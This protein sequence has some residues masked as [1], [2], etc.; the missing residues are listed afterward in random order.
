MEHA[1]QPTALVI[2]GGIA[3]LSA[4]WFLQQSRRMRI[5]LIEASGR[6]GGKVETTQDG[7]YRVEHGPD[8]FITRKPWALRLIRELGLHDQLVPLNPLPDRIAVLRG[9]RLVPMPEGLELLAPTELW[10]F[11]TS[12]LFSP[13]GKL[14]ILAEA[15]I[16]AQ[17]DDADESIAQF[18][19]RRFGREALERLGDP[20]LAG[21]YNA[22]AAQQSILA[23]FGRFRQIE[24]EHG[25]LIRGLRRLNGKAPA[26]STPALMSFRDGMEQFPQQLAARLT[27]DKHLSTSVETIEGHD[28]RWRAV[29]SDGHFIDADH[30]ILT[31]PAPTSTRLLRGI[32]PEASESLERIRYSSVG[33]ITLAFARADVRHQMHGYGAVIPP[34]EKRQIDGIQWSSS[35]WPDRAPA[36]KVLIRAFFGGPH[37]RT[38]MQRDDE[39]VQAI[40]LDELKAIMGVDAQP[41]KSWINRWRHAY[42]QYDI[43]HLERVAML[44]KQLPAGVHLTGSP[45]RGLGLPDIIHQSQQTAE[46]VLAQ[47]TDTTH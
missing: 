25:S 46:R 34:S 35:K 7:P 20:L 12:P 9:Q 27:A 43:G 10:P 32:A 4:A 41:E 28:G 23:S 15:L 37:T 45:Y 33:S 8:G 26:T 38:M 24:R 40:V 11:L 42:P 3:G 5:I 31:T 14:R 22:D 6:W 1:K 2:G 19:S 30:I 47:V 17:T 21:V 36:G 44:E 18:V 29:L 39:Q 13:T 16:P